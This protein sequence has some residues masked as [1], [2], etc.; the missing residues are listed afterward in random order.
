MLIHHFYPRTHNIG[1]HFV[2]RGI[3]AMFRSVVPAATFKLFDVNSRGQEKVE[4]GLTQSAVERANKEA[5]LIIVGGSNLYEGSFN[6]PWGVHL[7]PEALKNLRVPLFL[8]GVGTG[9]N[10]DSP[11]H[12]PSAR[13]KLEIRLLNDFATF[14]GVRDVITLDWLHQ[15]GV[16]KARLMGDPASFIFNNP[17]Q[18]NHGGHVLL[19]IPPRRIWTSRRQFWKVHT[20]GR[21]VFLALVEL[22]K[23]LSKKG[24]Q[25]VVTCNDPADLPLAQQLF[26]D[27]LPHAVICPETPED[28]FQLLSKSRAVISGRL[29]TA[30]VAF[31]LGIPFL[32]IDIDRRTHGFLQSYQLEPWSVVP[33]G[34]RLESRLN[35]QAMAL[36]DDSGLKEWQASI[37]KRDQMKEAA[38]GLIKEAMK[39]IRPGLR[40]I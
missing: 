23:T 9:S 13:A 27:W 4:Y 19:T 15:L 20:S 36:L 31:S 38:M 32:L 11:L 25:V 16:T 26:V 22:A 10:F 7:E 34:A 28:Y 6:W 8:V 1:D 5:D 12:K 14:S 17:L 21:P 2:Q 35:E 29:H 40:S 3:A 24:H 33:S 30:V 18:T 39:T 37:M